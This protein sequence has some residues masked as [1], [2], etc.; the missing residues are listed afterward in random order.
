M[1]RRLY[2]Q[3]Q[4]LKEEDNPYLLEFLKHKEKCPDDIERLFDPALSDE[5]RVEIYNSIDD[6]MAEV[7]SFLFTI[8]NLSHLCMDVDVCMGYSR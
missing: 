4:A 3:S 2:P 7:G 1:E 8:Y 5:R 6:S